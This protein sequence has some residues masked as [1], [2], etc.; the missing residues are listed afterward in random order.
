VNDVASSEI[1]NE[2]IVRIDDVD[3]KMED[4]EVSARSFF[5]KN[6]GAEDDGVVDVMKVTLLQAQTQTH[7][8]DPSE[9]DSDFPPLNDAEMDVDSSPSSFVG[10]GS[11]FM[12]RRMVVN[13]QDSYE[14]AGWVGHLK[15]GDLDKHGCEGDHEGGID[16]VDGHKH[17][18]EGDEAEEKLL[19]LQDG[20]EY[21]AS[22]KV[23]DYKYRPAV[24][25]SSSLYDWAR[26]SVKV[27]ISRKNN[28]KHVSSFYPATDRETLT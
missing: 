1:P 9:L 6:D 15:G 8:R 3:V 11:S 2:N 26:L 17:E 14:G 10:E 13:S 18:I 25:T 21:V 12:Q 28:K 19:I 23:D 24:Y 27:K 22:S 20:D 16:D 4:G 7:G 5:L